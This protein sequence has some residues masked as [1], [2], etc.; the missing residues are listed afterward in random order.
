MKRRDYRGHP[1][2]TIDA[3]FLPEE[4]LSRYDPKLYVFDSDSAQRVLDFFRL[5]LVHIEGEWAGKPLTPEEWQY[6]ILRDVFG[7]KRVADG[8]RK[9]RTVYEEVP[10]KNG[11]STLAAGVGLYLTFADR[12]P[13][14]KIFSAATDKDQA[15]IV[16]NTAADMVKA[17]PKLLERCELFEGK[18]TIYVPKGNSVYRVLSGVPRKSGLNAHGIIYDE[19]HEAPDR[20]LLDVLQ[21]STVARRQPLTWYATTAGFDEMTICFEVHE[22][23]LKVLE[24]IFDDP[25]FYPVIY[26]ADEEKVDSTG[27]IV[28]D[29]WTLEATWRKANPNFGISVKADY[30]QTEC[31]RAQEMPAYQNSFKRFH[32]NIWTRQ[33]ELWMPKDKWDPCGAPFNLA[34]LEG[35]TCYAGLDLSSTEDLTAEARV[36][37]ILDPESGLYHFFAKLNFWL[38]KENLTKREDLDKVPYGQW[39]KD[40][41]IELTKGN[42]IDYE[43]I[44]AEINRQGER[45]EIAEIAADRWNAAQIITQLADDGFVVFPFGQGFASMAGPTKQL[46]DTVLARTLHH[47]SNPVLNWNASNAAVETD[48]AGNWKLSKSAS[49][50][51]IDGMVALVMA[52]GRASLHLND[53]GDDEDPVVVL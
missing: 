36:W 50:K 4:D 44:R 34:A 7:W 29:D 12:E 32:L 1:R 18:G 22:H 30:L 39:A 33:N 8:T 14:A 38:P 27:K 40:G 13:G 2:A 53:G 31:K 51:R 45:S 6:K 42:I 25:S 20:K 9:Y 41:F 10:R 24:G 46:M 19:L 23:A 5:F 26:A 17:S 16:F 11:K 28:G 15:R 35:Q 52:L 49:R 47:A 21:T 37:P 3:W 43:F 48:A